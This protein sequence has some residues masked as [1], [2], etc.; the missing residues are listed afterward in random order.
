MNPNILQELPPDFLLIIAIA[1]IIVSLIALFVALDVRERGMTRATVIAWF[2]GVQL[3]WPVAL[4][5]LLVRKRLD[6]AYVPPAQQAVRIACPYCNEPIE[7][8]ARLCRSC[9]RLL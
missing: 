6:V 9:R 2:I 5:Y 7:P 8:G 1:Q 3:F 4:I